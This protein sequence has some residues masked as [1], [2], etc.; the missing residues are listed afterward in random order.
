VPEHIGSVKEKKSYFVV[1][2]RSTVFPE[3][4]DDVVIPALAEHSG[5]TPGKGFGICMVPE[6]L[7]EG[8]SV[9]DY[10]YLL[11]TVL[12]RHCHL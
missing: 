6:I 8:S 11:K 2:V 4:L 9:Y 7:C 1:G 10:Y 12:L 5:K 3:T